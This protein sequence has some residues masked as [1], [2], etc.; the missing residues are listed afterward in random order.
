VDEKTRL[1]DF[2]LK[3]QGRL[4]FTHD[5]DHSLVVLS[6]DDKGRYYPNLSADLKT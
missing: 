5:P 6:C 1:L 3:N 4:F 2:I